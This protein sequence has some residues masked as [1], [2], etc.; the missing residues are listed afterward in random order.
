MTR[1]ISAL[2]VLL[3]AFLAMYGLV[4]IRSGGQSS[5]VLDVVLFTSLAVS[6][7]GS[8][9]ALSLSPARGTADRTRLPAL[10]DDRARRAA[11]WRLISVLAIV[12]RRS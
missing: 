6:V 11:H 9:C 3:A 8:L 5:A 4:A 7:L 10:T 2:G 12:T 1:A